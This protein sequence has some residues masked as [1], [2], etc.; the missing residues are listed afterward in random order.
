MFARKGRKTEKSYGGWNVL[1]RRHVAS[2]PYQMRLQLSGRMLYFRSNDGTTQ[3]SGNP[4]YRTP[5]VEPLSG[6]CGTVPRAVEYIS[7][8]HTQPWTSVMNSRCSL[9]AHQSIIKR[10]SHHQ[11]VCRILELFQSLVSSD[12]IRASNEY[13]DIVV[14]LKTMLS[15]NA[16]LQLIEVVQYVKCRI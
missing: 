14:S 10:C 1:Q 12:I 11:L 4:L 5:K 2:K 7:T 9:H 16:Q 15:T 3:Q 8:Q 13:P 6:A